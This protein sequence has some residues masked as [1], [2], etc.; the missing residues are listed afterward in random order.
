[1]TAPFP[2]FETV[3][4]EPDGPLAWV[5]LNRPE[6]RNAMNGQM[7]ED[8]VG[9]IGA[10]GERQDVHV[11]GLRGEGPSFSS[12]YDIGRKYADAME[13]RDAIDEWN[14]LRLRMERMMTIWDSPL[15]VIAAVHGYCL[16]GATQL[17]TFCDLVIVADDAIIGS[18]GAGIGAGY[19]SPMY[20]LTVGIRRAKVL[21]MIPGHKITG[22]QAADWGWASWSVS[23]DLL[24][25]EVRKTAAII[26]LKPRDL[27]A[28]NK[29]AI[30]RVAELNGFRYAIHQLADIDVIAHRSASAESARQSLTQ[31]G[32]AEVAREFTREAKTATES[33]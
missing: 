8:L 12:G 6:K 5:V 32:P 29:I 20:V 13:S 2:S 14:D 33:T 25:D 28:A 16:A 1:M 15:P 9:A 27:V 23:E 10:L 24:L 22:A 26:A 3:R 17:C 7:L 4:I 18:P 19:V 21:G 11:I 30:N 31:Q